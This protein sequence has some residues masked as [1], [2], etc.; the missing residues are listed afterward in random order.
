MFEF[1]FHEEQVF[2]LCSQYSILSLFLSFSL[3]LSLSFFSPFLPFP[4]PSSLLRFL[5]FS[6]VL[7]F[8][9]TLSSFFCPS[10]PPSHAFPFPT[11]LPSP[12]F[13]SF[14]P[15]V[16]FFHL[17]QSLITHFHKT[18]PIFFERNLF[19]DCSFITFFLSFSP[20]SPL[21]PSFLPYYHPHFP[22]SLS[23]SLTQFY[24]SR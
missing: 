9:T 2:L 19:S 1:V 5:N 10:S 3:L 18:Y 17:C 16:I 6:L 23:I 12:Y 20:P 13:F 15:F 11:P 8:Q 7:S 24:F 22:L 21:L 14:P 4:T